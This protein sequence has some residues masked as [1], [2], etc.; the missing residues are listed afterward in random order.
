MLA[1][2]MRY[3]VL[4]A[5]LQ[6]RAVLHDLVR[7]EGVTRLAVADVSERALGAAASPR[8]GTEQVERRRLDVH[9]HAATV[10]AMRGFDV[11]IEMLPAELRLPVARAAL[12][13][14]VHL[15]NCHYAGELAA[16][17]A[18]VAG[19]GLRFMPEAGLD[20]G[21]DLVMAALAVR[22]LDEV[23]ELR[24][25]GA[26][27]PEPAAATGPLRYKLTWPLEAVLRS[28]VREAR[29][30][31]D[32]RE[33]R[34]AATEI[35]APE[36]IHR[37]DVPGLGTLEAYPNGDAVGYAE[38]LGIAGSLR[39]T[40]RYVLRWPGHAAL[41][42]PLVALGLLDA[43]PLDAADGA[44]GARYAPLQLLARVLEP[45][46]H[47]AEGERDVAIARVEVSGLRHGVPTRAVAQVIDRRDLATGLFAMNRTVGFTASIAAQLVATGAV[48]RAGVLSPATDLPV[49]R[50]CAELEQRGMVVTVATASG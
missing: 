24:S 45:K 18:E 16:L 38:R 9:D 40:G 39:S 28:Y 20:P 6:G 42:Y 7:S 31:V 34:I 5:G 3:L 47:Y 29:L 44:A 50:F 41:W 35:F 33:Q 25:Y 8:L 14:R 19:A 1:P 46:L 13:A 23:H 11:V 43:E 12:D 37:L 26:G 2:T 48:T 15:V 36:H 21:L 32:G 17:D 4:G 30:R 10:G 22:A 27:F 49:D